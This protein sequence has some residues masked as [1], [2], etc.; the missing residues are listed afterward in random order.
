MEHDAS[1]VR[2][3]Y[4]I[5]RNGNTNGEER[6]YIPSYTNDS[7]NQWQRG[8]SDRSYEHDCNTV[9]N[10][11][12]NGNLNY[13]GCDHGYCPCNGSYAESDSNHC[14]HSELCGGNGGMESDGDNV[15]R[16]YRIHLNGNAD[17]K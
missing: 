4:C 3:G 11:C 6:V 9:A 2:R 14:R 8:C 15:R 7:N 1:D 5:H 13:R 17:G 12:S 10:L 16:E